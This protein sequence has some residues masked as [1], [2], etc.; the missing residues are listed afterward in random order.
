[1]VTSKLPTRVRGL[2]Y[3]TD[4]GPGIARLGRPEAFT[5]RWP[6]GRVVKDGATLARIRSLVIPP[7]WTDVWIAP[8]AAGHIQATG[9]DARRRKQY[10]SHPEWRAVRDAAK[11]DHLV[12]FA[13][14]LPSIRAAVARDL[15]KP[16]CSRERVMAV[17]VTLLERT[18]IR[19]GNEEYAR[20]NDSYGLTT[21]KNGHARVRGRRV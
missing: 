12:E 9:R 19:V 5:Y 7:A 1:M 10:R 11:F 8:K 2:T 20:T 6:S 17:V 14:A 15:A 13:R 4:E 3:A 16:P 21:L 18:H